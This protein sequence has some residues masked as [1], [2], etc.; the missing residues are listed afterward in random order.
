MASRGSVIICLLAL[1]FCLKIAAGE[2]EIKANTPEEAAKAA[3]AAK[4][5]PAK[6]HGKPL[7]FVPMLPA[8]KK[9]NGD[10]KDPVWEKAAS[11]KMINVKN[12]TAPKFETEVRLFC[13]NEALYIGV[14]CDEPDPANV[15]VNNG[16]AWQNDSIEFFMYP[17]STCAGGKLYYQTV[18]DAANKF[19]QYY[20]HLYPKKGM[21]GLHGEWASKADHEVVK[22]EKAWTL[23]E[24][25][26][27][28]DL[29]FTPEAIAKKTA[30]RLDIFR[31]RCARG[32]EEAQSYGWTP[33]DES[34][35]Y[36]MP[37]RFG[38]ILPGAFVTADWIA[39]FAKDTE[40][41]PDEPPAPE[42]LRQVNDL[43][44]RLGHADYVERSLAT[45][46]LN[47]LLAGSRSLVP[48]VKNILTDTLKKTP[49]SEIKSRAAK[50][51]NSCSSLL[52]NDD[53]APPDMNKF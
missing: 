3:E 7:L 2:D 31:N 14:R 30:W 47:N 53:D 22:G 50:I 37:G 10:L 34:G 43:I 29:K 24:R 33:T 27:F 20:C 26:P 51:I 21:Q 17:G 35:A 4:A 6:Y 12:Q 41:K 28:S 5:L 25:L 15:A 42:L 38:Y 40:G 39:E 48:V 23:E 44:A 32:E 52:S 36:H 8:P 9:L 49:D 18:V 45:D 19:E 16:F 1:T 11:F 46:G 13:S